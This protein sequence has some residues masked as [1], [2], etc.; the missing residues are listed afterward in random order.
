MLRSRRAVVRIGAIVAAGFAVLVMPAVASAYGWPVAPVDQQHAIRG[1]FDDPRVRLGPGGL[2]E[3]SFHFGVDIVAPDG[4]PVYAVAPGTVYLYPDAVAVR[5]ADGHE[6]SYWHIDA[7]VGEHSFARTGDL[8]GY[9]RKGWGHVH[10]AESDGVDGY[11]NPLRP[12]ALEP[13]S[14]WTTPVVGTIDLRGADG[15][16]V[17]PEDVHGR[18]EVTVTAYDP[19]PI[20]PPPPWQDAEL[21]PALVRWRVVHDGREVVPWHT[22]ADFRLRWQPPPEFGEIYA[23]GTNQNHPEQPGRYDFWLA[24][25]LDTTALPNG[26]ARIEVEAED[27]RGNVGRGSL[28]IDVQNA[29]SLKTTKR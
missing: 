17:R 27:T 12:G 15:G 21:T 16:A 26:D 24:H 29:Q 8:L 1:A 13:F 14:D 3:S 20:A 7:A 23:P 18:I 4:T 9:V 25:G 2:A 5:M 10:F 22:A 19:P 28:A 6:F 11:L